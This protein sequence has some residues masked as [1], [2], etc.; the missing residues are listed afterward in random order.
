MLG[1]GI[2][3]VKI[4][5]VNIDNPSIVFVKEFTVINDSNVNDDEIVYEIS[6]THNINDGTYKLGLNVQNSP[7]PMTQ[8]YT[9]EVVSKSSSITSV[10]IDAWGN[11]TIDG[12]GWIIIKG[13]DYVY[14]P[15]Y[16]VVLNLIVESE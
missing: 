9:W 4:M 14:N 13:S 10:T 5:A 7:F 1:V 8:Y 16:S 15:K 2:G 11:V 6:D 3:T 12:A